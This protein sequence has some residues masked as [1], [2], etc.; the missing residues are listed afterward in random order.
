MTTERNKIVSI[1]TSLHYPNG[2]KTEEFTFTLEAVDMFY[3]KRNI[4]AA[5]IKLGFVDGSRDGGVD[6]IYSNEETL[7][8]IQ[9]KSSSTLTVEDVENALNKMAK[10]FTKFKDRKYDE[11]NESVKNALSNAYDDLTDDKNVELVLFTKTSFD[12]TTKKKINEISKSDILNKFNI[13]VYDRNDIDLQ[14]AI[15]EESSDLV[16]EGQ[17]RL[18]DNEDKNANRLSFGNGKGIIVNI[19]ASSLKN[20]YQQFNKHGLFSY[21]LREHITQKNVDDAIDYTIKK[22]PEKFWYYNNGITIGCNDYSI[23][24]YKI[25]LYGFSIINGAQTTTKIGKSN[26]VNEKHDFALTCKIVRAD[27]SFGDEE[28][29]ISK[30]SEA[31]NSQKPIKS[32]DLKSNLKEQ[33]IMQNKAADNGKYSLSIEIKRGVHPSNYKSVEKWQRVQNDYV[34]QLIYSCIFQHPGKAR[35]SKNTMFSSKDVYQT[36]FH[37]NHDYNTLFDLVRIGDAYDTYVKN[38]AETAEGDDAIERLSMAKNAKLSVL[39]VL[40]YLLKKKRGIIKDRNSDGLHQDNI[41]GFL[42]SKY[43]GD[44]LDKLLD[45]CF[46]FVI[47]ELVRIY[48]QNENALKLTSYSNF[49]KTDQYY[50][51]II[52]QSFDDLDEYDIEKIGKFMEVFSM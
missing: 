16:E 19:C 25:K 2:K 7:Y 38:L 50:D 37:R 46:S 29:F 42:V 8:L 39:A 24:G 51:D 3:Y 36:I 20:L 31:S 34:G 45:N 6:Y 43:P 30:I 1:L 33:R 15:E 10:T 9:G 13:S 21:N 28:D 44:D 27:K 4:G 11:F 12:K 41:K 18:F 40:C 32:R 17:L 23:D 22:E 26:I 35:N 5:D 49:L 48:K 14:K 52:L 47:R